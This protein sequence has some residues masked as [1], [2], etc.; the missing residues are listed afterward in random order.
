M[1]NDCPDCREDWRDFASTTSEHV[2]VADQL[3]RALRVLN[4]VVLE[5]DANR[6]DVAELRRMVPLLAGAPPDVL[7]WAVFEQVLK[8]RRLVRSELYRPMDPTG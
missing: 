2:L 5:H 6:A 3:K 1:F 4:A 7:A 8:H